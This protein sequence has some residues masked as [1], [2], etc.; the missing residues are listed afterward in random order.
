MFATCKVLAGQK[1][2]SHRRGS[3]D[4]SSLVTATFRWS[5]SGD[6][7]DCSLC[8][9]FSSDVQSP[10]SPHKVTS[11]HCVS[12]SGVE[13]P[14]FAR[15]DESCP[16]R[17]PRGWTGKLVSSGGD[18][19]DVAGTCFGG[20]FLQRFFHLPV[21]QHMTRSES[22][23]PR[24]CTGSTCSARS[25]RVVLLD[26]QRE[27]SDP[28]WS[29]F[30]SLILLD[31]FPV[32]STWALWPGVKSVASEY[33]SLTEDPGAKWV[34]RWEN[35]VHRWPRCCL[36]HL[37]RQSYSINIP[38]N[39]KSVCW[40][41]WIWMNLQY[42]HF[43]WWLNCWLHGCS[44]RRLQFSESVGCCSMVPLGQGLFA[45]FSFRQGFGWSS[46][47]FLDLS[48]RRK[49]HS[50]RKKCRVHF[51]KV[52]GEICGPMPKRSLR[53]LLFLSPK[54]K[55]QNQQTYCDPVKRSNIVR[56]CLLIPPQTKGY[57]S[58]RYLEPFPNHGVLPLDFVGITWSTQVEIEE[59]VCHA[60]FKAFP[61]EF[62]CFENFC[63]FAST[64]Q[65]DI[66]NFQA[67]ESFTA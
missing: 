13:A 21:L 53:P 46:T 32:S 49:W 20:K 26:S 8:W 22:F 40:I 36:V 42:V 45:F 66:A 11:R 63:G 12:V 1:A 18:R 5:R 55:Q 33:P 48:L 28:S 25:P 34:Q 43:R 15:R 64:Q 38:W 24:R 67:A 41:L 44:W 61:F 4:H 37:V 39:L 62:W 51:G 10:H 30:N 16:R 50:A 6:C 47:K 23:G 27:W 14:K 35:S 57:Q 19:T 65:L 3:T 60:Y 56:R 7:A 29:F 58:G 52:F 9:I 54:S 31:R 59:P 17:W 2:L